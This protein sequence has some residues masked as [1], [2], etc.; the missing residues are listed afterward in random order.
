MHFLAQLSNVMPFKYKIIIFQYDSR[1]DQLCHS[2]IRLPII[3]V[4]LPYSMLRHLTP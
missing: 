3:E 2:T 4:C 1:T